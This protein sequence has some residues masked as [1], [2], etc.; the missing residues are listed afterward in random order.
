MRILL[1]KQKLH[2][3]DLKNN[4]NPLTWIEKFRQGGVRAEEKNSIN[5]YKIIEKHKNG[6]NNIK[7]L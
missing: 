5:D 7:N 3:K 2:Q 4:N 6:Y 1:K